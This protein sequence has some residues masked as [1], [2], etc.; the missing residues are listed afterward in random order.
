MPTEKE[1]PR[2]QP[3]N[4]Q[5]TLLKRCKSGISCLYQINNHLRDE[6]YFSQ[7]RPRQTDFPERLRT[8]QIET[9]AKSSVLLEQMKQETVTEK[10]IIGL[11]ISQIKYGLKAAHIPVN[12]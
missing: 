7:R 3:S 10:G 9:Q 11:Q 12:I 8:Y 6:I 2:V 1:N 4:F 5:P